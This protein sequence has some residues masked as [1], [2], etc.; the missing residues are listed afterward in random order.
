M[1][2][3]YTAMSRWINRI[4]VIFMKGAALNFLVVERRRFLITP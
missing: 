1:K 2:S 3:A 4:P